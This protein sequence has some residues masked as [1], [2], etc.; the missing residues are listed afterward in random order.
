MTELD[1]NKEHYKGKLNFSIVVEDTA[2][3]DFPLKSTRLLSDC[4]LPYL[5]LK[6]A[7]FSFSNRT[8]K[9]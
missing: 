3:C 5:G 6:V 9:W 2:G 8:G 4:F 1:I 7:F